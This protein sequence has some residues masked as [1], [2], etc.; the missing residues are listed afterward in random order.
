METNQHRGRVVSSVGNS[1]RD[2]GTSGRRQ[3]ASAEGAAATPDVLK[4]WQCIRCGTNNADLSK[5]R[6]M[7]CKQF[8]VNPGTWPPEAP[9][10]RAPN[11]RCARWSVPLYVHPPRDGKENLPVDLVWTAAAPGDWLFTASWN[12]RFLQNLLAHGLFTIPDA[13]G[14]EGSA[15]LMLPNRMYT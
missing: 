5:I 6:C 2:N 13:P 4:T 15:M 10:V 14:G 3:P 12:Y 9:V 7:Q 11:W 1:D 8:A